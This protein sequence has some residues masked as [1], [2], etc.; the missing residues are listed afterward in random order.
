[1]NHTHVGN[2]KALL[3]GIPGFDSWTIELT[4]S[5]PSLELYM[6]LHT[7]DKALKKS[8]TPNA[9]FEKATKK[10]KRIRSPALKRNHNGLKINLNSVD[11]ISIILSFFVPRKKR[12][13]NKM[14][15][16]LSC[17]EGK[18]LPPSSVKI[19][20]REQTSLCIFWRFSISISLSSQFKWS[21]PP[22]KKKIKRFWRRKKSLTLLS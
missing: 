5:F 15:A 4:A 18:W 12:L 6:R 10:K 21:P 7:A 20:L 9:G 8:R 3:K 11:Y 19:T 13:K 16:F 22:N 17:F 2:N 14:S 1:M